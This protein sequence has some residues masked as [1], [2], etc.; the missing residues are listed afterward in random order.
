MWLG[1]VCVCVCV[2]LTHEAA[3]VTLQIHEETSQNGFKKS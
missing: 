1:G 2:L 3:G